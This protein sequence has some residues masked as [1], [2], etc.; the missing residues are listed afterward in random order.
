MPR[1]VGRHEVQALM[2]V[3]AQVVEVLSRA[4]YDERHL[5]GAVDIPLSELGE[6][7]P[8]ELDPARPV[9]TYCHDFL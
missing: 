3:G 4:E 9:V 5:E 8:R 7:A 2:A 6:R 1:T